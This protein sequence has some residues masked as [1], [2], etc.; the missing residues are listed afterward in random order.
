MF[1]IMPGLADRRGERVD[2]DLEGRRGGGGRLVQDRGEEE[3]GHGDDEAEDRVVLDVGGL[4]VDRARAVLAVEACEGAA[5]N[6][7]ERQAIKE[8][9][10]QRGIALDDGVAELVLREGVEESAIDE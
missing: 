6:A 4:V 1:F 3:E 7:D 10:A 2:E 9:V 5:R 8:D